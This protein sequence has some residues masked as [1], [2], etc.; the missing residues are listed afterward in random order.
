MAEPKLLLM[1]EPAQG[2]SPKA[3]NEV[4]DI[5][6]E[7]N[8]NGM[9]IIVVEHNIKLGVGLADT[10]FVLENGKIAF[11]ASANDLSAVECAKRMYLGA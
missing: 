6:T 1:D 3:A 11:T 10:I 7:I 8:H 4:A 2:L 5:I 9:T